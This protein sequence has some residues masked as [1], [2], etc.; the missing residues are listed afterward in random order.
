MASKVS[1]KQKPF[2]ICLIVLSITLFLLALNFNVPRHSYFL[3]VESKVNLPRKV[4]SP[5][6]TVPQWFRLV[7]EEIRDYNEVRVGLVNI[8]N[9]LN[10]D[11]AVKGGILIETVPLKFDH[12]SENLTWNDFFPQWIDEDQILDVPQCPEIPIP[13]LEDYNNLNLTVARVPS[14]KIFRCED[15]IR[16]V[17]DHWVYRPEKKRL[18]QIVHMPVGSCQLA[19]P[20]AVTEKVNSA[21]YHPR[22]AYAMSLKGLRDAGR[23]IKQIERIRSPY[24]MTGTYNE[25]NHSKLRVWQLTDYDKVIF[26]DADLL[27]FQNIDKFFVYPELSVVKNSRDMFNS[28]VMVLEPSNCLFKQMMAKRYELKSYNGGDQHQGF[29][30][31]IFTWWHRLPEKLNYLNCFD[32]AIDQEHKIPE[33]TYT[34]H[35][36]GWKPWTCYRD[37]D[38]NWDTDYSQKFA[39]DCA[40]REWWKLYDSMA[41]ELQSY[42]RLTENM[43]SRIREQRRI[44]RNASFPDGH[45][46]IKVTDDRGLHGDE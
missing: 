1:S 5:N 8:G 6:E 40:H 13:A 25:W 23:K 44:A 4:I 12:V 35:F 9:E 10:T 14:G 34:I 17:G 37:Y 39:S 30:N 26:I 29:P 18:E 42:C 16:K 22:E 41:K 33:N 36:L 19:P 21:T 45:W 11:R 27:V 15:L 2:I 32:S 7:E 20:Y 28:G 38:C 31:E 24:A 3:L 43:E 46:K